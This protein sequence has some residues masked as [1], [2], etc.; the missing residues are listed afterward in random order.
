MRID[1]NSPFLGKEAF[2][3]TKIGIPRTY[4]ENIVQNV[5]IL[6][7]FDTK[8][9]LYCSQNA[10]LPNSLKRSA[11]RSE[12]AALSRY[13][14]RHFPFSHL[15]RSAKRPKTVI[16]G[17]KNTPFCS[18]NA[19]LPNG[20]K[21][22]AKT[23]KNRHFPAS[24]LKRSA[25]RPKL[26]IFWPKNAPFC[27]ENANLPN[28]LKRSAKRSEFAAF[29]RYKN[30]HFPVSRLKRSAKR[31]KLAIF[32]PK[33]RAVLQRERQFATLYLFHAPTCDS[34]RGTRHRSRALLN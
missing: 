24:R 18:K 28:S 20:L 2:G 23:V 17:P 31:P 1:R 14:N 22:S 16:F 10:N 15:K 33:K 4:T 9:A 34:V 3:T 19:N 26:A 27:S 32:W 29:S 30:R 25:K 11:K 6:P 13:K 8:D 12:F 21:R 7:L 5:R